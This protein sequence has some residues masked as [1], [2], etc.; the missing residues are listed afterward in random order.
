MS[1]NN[2]ISIQEKGR[3]NG[4]VWHV[5]AQDADTGH[6]IDE[7]GVYGELKNAVVGA[8][9]YIEANEVEYG[10][11]IQPLIEK[12]ITFI[13]F[14]YSHI[15]LAITVRPTLLEQAHYHQMHYLN[16]NISTRICCRVPTSTKHPQMTSSIY[17]VS[18][19][20]TF[21]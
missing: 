21:I 1:A 15:Q 14:L 7:I 12:P 10:I 20:L 6:C 3:D 5:Q 11:D 8:N 13:E 19:C 2:F 18:F 17:R 16:N 4:T 9:K